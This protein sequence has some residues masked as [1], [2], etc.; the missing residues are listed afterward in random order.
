MRKVT[1]KAKCISCGA[2][3]DIGAGE[4]PADEMPMCHKCG[5]I[6][7]AVRAEAKG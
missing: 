2:T 7:V 6:M 5:N 1:V 4:V 3:R